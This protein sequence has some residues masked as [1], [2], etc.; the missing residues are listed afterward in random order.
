MVCRKLQRA[1]IA[2]SNDV[3]YD[4]ETPKKKRAFI[5]QEVLLKTSMKLIKKDFD[6]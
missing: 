1:I 2:H 6:N 3:D 5:K 4:G